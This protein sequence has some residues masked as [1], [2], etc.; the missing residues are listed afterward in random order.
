MSCKFIKDTKN[1]VNA[2]LN[3]QWRIMYFI[4]TTSRRENFAVVVGLDVSDDDTEMIEDIIKI[5]LHRPY[6]I[7]TQVHIPTTMKR[8]AIAAVYDNTMYVAGIGS[9][10][11]EIW[12]Y[13][14]TSGWIKC[15]S[16][17]QG[18]RRHSGAFIDEVLYICGGYVEYVE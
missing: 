6:E 11:D 5:N 3:L 12:K 17:V 7:A 9:N 10:S 8:E 1:L 14:Q 16:L 18:R 4:G 13:N 2:L 15:A